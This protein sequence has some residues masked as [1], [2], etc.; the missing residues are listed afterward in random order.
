[1]GKDPK[2]PNF[3]SKLEQ[4]GEHQST[5]QSSSEPTGGDPRSIHNGGDSS[6]VKLVDKGPKESCVG[7][8]ADSGVP[9]AR[10]G[11]AATK[12]RTSSHP[13]EANT[14]RG[15]PSLRCVGVATTKGSSSQ[16]YSSAGVAKTTRGDPFFQLVDKDPN[17]SVSDREVEGR[18]KRWKKASSCVGRK[19]FSDKE[20]IDM[21]ELSSDDDDVEARDK[22]LRSSRKKKAQLIDTE[23]SATQWLTFCSSQMKR[24]VSTS[25]K[26]DVCAFAKQGR[27]NFE[28]LIGRGGKGKEVSEATRGREVVT[29][30]VSIYIYEG[31]AHVSTM[32]VNLNLFTSGKNFMMRYGSRYS[33]TYSQVQ[34]GTERSLDKVD[35]AEWNLFSPFAIYF[36]K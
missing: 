26:K 21:K 6:Y 34:G 27:R 13:G 11:A 35:N 4:S 22:L 2:N 24:K 10:V 31:D 25:E 30:R 8:P 14:A 12:G 18:N 28:E 29:R 23:N 9:Q 17:N 33:I 5:H 32:E 20:L 1:M 7:I 16:P 3:T 15:D 36:R 19:I